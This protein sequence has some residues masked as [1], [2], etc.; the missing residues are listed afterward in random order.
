LRGSGKKNFL[1][2]AHRAIAGERQFVDI[3]CES[4]QELVDF[5]LQL[6]LPAR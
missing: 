4:K 5:A 2:I 3:F 1:D 6:E